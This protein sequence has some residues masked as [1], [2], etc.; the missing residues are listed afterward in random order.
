MVI[1]YP[2]YATAGD[3][4]VT[5]AGLAA[6]ATTSAVSVAAEVVG[7]VLAPVASNTDVV[8]AVM[9]MLIP[10]QWLLSDC[11]GELPSFV[12]SSACPLQHP[13]PYPPVPFIVPGTAGTGDSAPV[14]RLDRVLSYWRA[15]ELTSSIRLKLCLA[16]ASGRNSWRR[17][18]FWLI[19][20]YQPF[21]T[22]GDPVVTGAGLAAVVS[23]S[24]AGVVA[25]AVGQGLQAVVSNPA[26]VGT[27]AVVVGGF[28]MVGISALTGRV[29]CPHGR[30]VAPPAQ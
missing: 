29:P 23:H 18:I 27:A 7:R 28:A 12:L 26:A 24:A 16:A 4:V 1:L 15:D 8:A 19:F 10:C 3:P 2:L 20:L 22:A 30:C 13:L 21:A 14:V 17:P 25:G 11:R 9:L 6:G 5:V